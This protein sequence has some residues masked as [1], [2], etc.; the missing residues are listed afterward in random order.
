MIELKLI[1]WDLIY[2]DEKEHSSN[3]SIFIKDYNEIT[4]ES[5]E[6]EIEKEKIL[7]IKRRK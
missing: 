3:K 6:I 4:K 7:Y 2:W 1:N 5:F